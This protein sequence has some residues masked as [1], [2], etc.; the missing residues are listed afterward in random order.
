MAVLASTGDSPGS[1]LAIRLNVVVVHGFAFFPRHFHRAHFA[2]FV[3]KGHA[4]S[5]VVKVD[6]TNLIELSRIQFR[7]DVEAIA[8]EVL[9]SQSQTRFFVFEVLFDA[10]RI[11]DKPTLAALQLHLGA[12]HESKGL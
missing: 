2:D 3:G 4:K 9:S 12:L 11:P 6:I 8:Q 5:T 7:M 1:I 10:Q